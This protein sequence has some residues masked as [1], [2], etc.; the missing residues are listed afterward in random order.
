MECTKVM[1][2]CLFGRMHPLI[3]NSRDKFP[4]IDTKKSKKEIHGLS[5]FRLC[6]LFPRFSVCSPALCGVPWA[7]LV[8]GYW[9]LVFHMHIN[10]P[11]SF[12][13]TSACSVVSFFSPHFAGF[14]GYL[15]LYV[16][17]DI[18]FFFSHKNIIDIIIYR[19]Y[20]HL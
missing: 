1:K 16:T 19:F 9:L 4:R 6:S 5:G 15:G 18:F 17:C 12:S 3:P 7:L 8:P 11:S 10:F 14:R 13:A 20:I 2:K